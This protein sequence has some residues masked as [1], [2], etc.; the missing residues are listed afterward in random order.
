MCV[1]EHG[2]ALEHTCVV[3]A[4]MYD[5]SEHACLGNMYVVS[6]MFE[7]TQLHQNTRVTREDVCK[8]HVCT[9]IK[10][11]IGTQIRVEHVNVCVGTQNFIGTRVTWEH[12]CAMSR[13]WENRAALEHACNR[14]TCVQRHTRVREHSCIRTRV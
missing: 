13:V 6:H 5:T 10:T 3:G 14:A 4:C 7:R 9:G 1:R 8:D 12:V 11:L 2:T